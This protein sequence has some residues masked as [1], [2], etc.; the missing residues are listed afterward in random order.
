MRPILIV[1]CSVLSVFPVTAADWTE[2]RGP[3]AQGHSA[4][5]HLP[6]VWGVDKNVLWKAP[7]AGL[8]WS[9]PVVF[10]DQVF[11]TTSVSSQGVHSPEQTLQTLSLDLKTGKVR[12]SVDV[13]QQKSVSPA[14]DK[15]H[16]KNSQA[17]PTP[18]TDGKH[19]YVHFGTR[20]TACLTLD[21]KIV[22]TNQEL[23]YQPVHGNGGS[24]IIVDDK[25]I[26]SC[27]G[28]DVGF[29]VALD[30]VTGKV[31]W[32]TDR[33]VD[34]SPKKFAFGTPLLI[35]ASG[36]R[37]VIS[38]GTGAVYG[39]QVEDGKEL[40]RARYGDGY[41][42]IPR[43]VYSHGLLFVGSGYDKPTMLAV[44]PTVTGDVT[45]SHVRWTLSRGAP[46]TPSPLVV[47]D[48][49]YLVS[50]GGIA[51]CVD[52]VTGNEHWQKRLGGNYSAS[53][54]AANGNIYFQ[55]EA[56]EG[57]IVKAD[58]AYTEVARNQL[59]GRTFASYAVAGSSLLIRTEKNLYRIGSPE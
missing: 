10:G 6:T 34:N 20:G 41:S 11:L 2:F 22:W 12:W 55:S 59:E 51:T 16:S 27:D 5:N 31:L 39:Y 14:V 46:H 28:G 50:D 54:I 33:S 43:P 57:I 4:E 24:P 30:R 15:V 25:L 29:M 45:N 52:A 1:M 3:S 23:K 49:L 56:G 18:I 58:K 42:V 40:W 9:S 7:I 21:G 44:D 26:L 47:G 37:Q 8:G 13:F 36:K 19:L 53:P 35:E 32:R 17:S 38:Q 48:E